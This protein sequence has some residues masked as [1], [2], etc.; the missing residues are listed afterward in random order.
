M[1]PTRHIYAMDHIAD[2]IED[3]L[4]ELRR[5]GNP[6][7]L[8]GMARFGINTSH[9]YGNSMPSVRALAKLVGRN[10][11][12]A[13]GL[14]ETG[15]HDARLLC[16]FIDVPREV[17]EEQMDRWAGDFNSWDLTDQVCNNLFSRTAF[18]EAAIHRWAAREEEYVR[19]AAFALIA[20]M[21]VHGPG[22]PDER[23]IAWFSVIDAASTDER[24]YVKKAVNWALRQIGKRNMRLHD[25]AVAVAQQLLE[26]D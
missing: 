26:R 10:H 2:S 8:E 3:V 15:I 6:A 19:R 17:T 24:Y 12:L 11:A 20:S 13:L 1:S 25:A 14:W 16:A 5:T 22:I 4:A 18:A 21:A 23:F 7:S 9:A